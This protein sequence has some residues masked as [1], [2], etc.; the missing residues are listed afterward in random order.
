[1]EDNKI[2]IYFDES[3]SFTL[4]SDNPDLES[5]MKKAIELKDKIN[6][7]SIEI[8]CNTENFDSDGFKKIIKNS[9]Q[10][11]YNDID[12]NIEDLNKILKCDD[13]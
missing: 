2:Y 9:F 6:L 13:N 3:N 10:K 8:K 4:N 11:F 7:D 1:M 12:I 5:L